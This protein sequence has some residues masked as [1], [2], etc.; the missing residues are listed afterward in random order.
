MSMVFDFN[1][2]MARVDRDLVMLMHGTFGTPETMS[3][4]DPLAELQTLVDAL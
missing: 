1:M 2:Y 4:F 3:G